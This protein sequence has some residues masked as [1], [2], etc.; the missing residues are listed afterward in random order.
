MKNLSGKGIGAGIGGQ[1]SNKG[2]VPIEMIDGEPRF[3][4][5]VI[6][7]TLGEGVE[8]RGVHGGGA[9]CEGGAW[10]WERE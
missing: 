5:A 4:K 8:G 2:M 9:A 10:E 6:A 3:M 1:F 7:E